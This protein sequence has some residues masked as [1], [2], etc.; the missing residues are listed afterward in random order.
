[1]FLKKTFAAF[2]AL[3][4]LESLLHA[5]EDRFKK[6]EIRVI[7]PKFFQKKQRLELGTQFIT[8]TNQTFIY[9]YLASGI[10]D[11]HFNE[12]LAIEATGAYGFSFDK[13]DKTVL[14]D[15]FKISTV[16]L[17][18]KY[19]FESALVYTPIYGKYQLSSGKLI[20]FDTF[21]TAGGGMTGVEYLY[22][23]C[24]QPGDI[25]DASVPITTPPAPQTKTYPGGVLGIG[26][27]FFLDKHRAIRWDLKDH[28]FSYSRVDGACD[29]TTALD[30]GSGLQ[31]NI[32]IQIGMSY[33]L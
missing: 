23:H 6:F 21:L 7:R 11:F 31:Q 26:Q 14:K 16:I 15:N 33:F 20:Y 29:P 10:L 1:M 28:I 12:S 27:R 22:D 3:I 25:P 24:K 2:L 17:R 4:F 32:T 18:T 8:V 13:Q 19:F 30:T 5:E 9:T